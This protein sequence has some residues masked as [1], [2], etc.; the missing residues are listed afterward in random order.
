[1][2]NHMTRSHLRMIWIDSDFTKI[3]CPVFL[4]CVIIKKLCCVDIV[5]GKKRLD[6][7]RRIVCR[8]TGDRRQMSAGRLSDKVSGEPGKMFYYIAGFLFSGG[9]RRNL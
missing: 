7:H 4:N 2:M 8:S 5:H 6:G 3:S 1:M 9:D